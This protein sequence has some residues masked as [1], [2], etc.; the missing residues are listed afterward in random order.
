MN[1]T[2]NVILG[3]GFSFHAGIPMVDKIS[4]Q[5]NRINKN[6]ILR[7]SSEEW[8]WDDINEKALVNN[9]RLGFDHIAGG[10]LLDELVKDFIKCSKNFTNYEVFF[11][12]LL[13]N[14]NTNKCW[15]HNIFTKALAKISIEKPN[16]SEDYKV[17]LR[18]P[19]IAKI[20]SLI[21][22]LISDILKPTKSFDEY[23]SK[24]EPFI[25]GIKNYRTVNIFSLNH[26][27]LLEFLLQSYNIIYS[28]GF[29]RYNSEVVHNGAPQRM[30]QNF[31]LQEGIRLFKV[32]GSLD[33]ID[34]IVMN[35]TGSL[36]QR[37]GNHIYFKPDNYYAKH[38][39]A[40]IDLA[41]NQV[42]QN[43]QPNISPFFV[44]GD[45]KL[46]LIEQNYVF[47]SMFN[48]MVNGLRTNADL[49]IIGYS[50]GDEHINNLILENV[51]KYKPLVVNINP[52][53]TFCQADYSNT[54]NLSDILEL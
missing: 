11:Q 44:T 39:S 36:L 47:N 10:Y 29:S 37:T 30:F 21:N 3:A 2:L 27:I 19:T 17:F 20:I 13:D 33:I 53:N 5:F 24:Y 25:K 38:N 12:Y 45:D 4:V 23:G 46:N 34:F 51:S 6:H 1:Q 40:R 18:Y 43:F 50:Y 54:I 52:N 15:V 35:Q 7:Q 49:F 22:E 16:L 9:G 26:D 31:F 41:T 8:Q 32:H 28:D 48:H 14:G 42:V